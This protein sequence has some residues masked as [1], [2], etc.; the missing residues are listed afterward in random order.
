MCGKHKHINQAQCCDMCRARG[1]PSAYLAVPMS[2]SQMYQRGQE[3]TLDRK[4]CKNEDEMQ[5]SDDA[6]AASHLSVLQEPQKDSGKYMTIQNN[7][8]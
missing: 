7:R 3:A 4:T 6:R 8:V 5:L 2:A 1:L